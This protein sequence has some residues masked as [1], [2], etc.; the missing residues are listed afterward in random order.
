MRI[1]CFFHIAGSEGV[2]SGVI[3]HLELT[4]RA[5]SPGRSAVNS[6]TPPGRPATPMPRPLTVLAQTDITTDLFPLPGQADYI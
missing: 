6:T 1:I 3:Y 4:T 2:P 5:A